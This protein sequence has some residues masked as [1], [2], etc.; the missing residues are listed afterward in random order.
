MAYKEYGLSFGGDHFIPR[1]GLSLQFL[2]EDNMST[3]AVEGRAK[4]AENKAAGKLLITSDCSD[5][6]NMAIQPEKEATIRSV[7]GAPD[8]NSFSDA[9]RNPIYA[10]AVL[11]GHFAGEHEI[12]GESPA[13]CGARGV[14]DKLLKGAEAK[15]DIEKWVQ[16]H[17]AHS[18]IILDLFERSEGISR[19]TGKDLLLVA[20]DHLD[21]TVYPVIAFLNKP[22]VPPTIDMQEYD[23]TVVYKTGIPHLTSG[24]LRDS[25]FADYLNDYYTKRFPTL[26]KFGLFDRTSQLEQN[27]KVLLITTETMPAELWLPSLVGQPGRVFVETLARTKK[28]ENGNINISEEDLSCLIKQTDYP[29]HFSALNTVL[30]LTEDSVQSE[31]IFTRLKRVSKFQ[32]WMEN[33]SHKVITGQINNGVISSA[34]TSLK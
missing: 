17:V 22:L 7:G 9:F 5:S 3:V 13:G 30:V 12:E 8:F 21:Q 6:R 28:P 15:S 16:E 20:R 10:G 19:Q 1:E 27:P 23:P 32:N 4:H 11:I 26:H 34:R 24:Q 29:L 14:K 2:R 25:V 18:D 33:S 31:K